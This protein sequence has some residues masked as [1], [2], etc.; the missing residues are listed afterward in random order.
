MV[1]FKEKREL[2]N[3]F[4]AKQCTHIE[5]GSNLPTQILRRTS[6]FFNTINFTEDDFLSFIRK[7]NPNKAHEPDQISIGMLQI[8]DK[9]ICKPLHLIFS[10]FMESGIFP[11]ER[12]MAN[13]YLFINEMANRMVKII[14]LFHFFQFFEKYLNVLHTIKC[15]NFYRNDLISPILAGF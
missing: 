9:E 1:D 10:S 13:V 7:L 11:A 8:C 2:F 15:T 5:T 6:E 12:K 3:S 4:F 14:D